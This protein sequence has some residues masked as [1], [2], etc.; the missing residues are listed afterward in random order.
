M[1]K[2]CA[3]VQEV[4]HRIFMVAQMVLLVAGGVS[5]QQPPEV[6]VENYVSPTGD[7]SIIAGPAELPLPSP[8]EPSELEKYQEASG[9]KN[10]QIYYEYDE[11]KLV[12]GSVSK[13]YLGYY[14]RDLRQALMP[15]G[16]ANVWYQKQPLSVRGDLLDRRFSLKVTVKSEG[17]TE[18]GALEVVAHAAYPGGALEPEAE[19]LEVATATDG[20]TSETVNLR[21][22]SGCL[23]RLNDNIGVKKDDSL[24]G[25]LGVKLSVLASQLVPTGTHKARAALQ[26][27]LLPKASAAFWRSVNPYTKGTPH[28]QISLSIPFSVENGGSAELTQTINIMFRPGIFRCG[29]CVLFGAV[30]A[31]ALSLLIS[32]QTAAKTMVVGGSTTVVGRIWAVVLRIFLSAVVAVIIFLVYTL[33]KGDKAVV[34]FDYAF[35]PTQLLPSFIIGLLVGLRPLFWWDKLRNVFGAGGGAPAQTG[36]AARVLLLG[37]LGLG[38]LS[39]SIE[40]AAGQPGLRP[41]NVSYDERSDAVYCLDSSSNV[42]FRVR[43]GATPRQ[44]EAMGKIQVDGL[45]LDH[46]L[47]KDQTRTW[48]AIVVMKGWPS[49]PG[50]QTF[51]RYSLQLAPLGDVLRSRTSL[52]AQQLTSVVG[53]P[54][55]AF[56]VATS[57]VF[58]DDQGAGAIFA[59]PLV[60][61]ELGPEELVF[62]HS[63][64]RSP[65]C[66]GVSGDKLFVGDGFTMRVYEI[67]LAQK[68][69]RTLVREV[70]DP[71]AVAVAPSGQTL[72]VADTARSRV[73]LC[74]LPSGKV[75]QNIGYKELRE[76]NGVA[77][78]S[79][80]H[81]WVSDSWLGALLEFAPDGHL[82]ARYRP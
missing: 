30:L 49:A 48:L 64:L 63:N 79:Q 71:T 65:Q 31:A 81:I 32:S 51:A 12:A 26:L 45:A 69:L 75:L 36:G 14:V 74:A 33:V 44:L 61:G 42:L 82:L 57:R 8:I 2:P 5:A 68:T 67:N 6:V 11:N 50:R 77:F 47:V 40:A 25:D 60:S 13:C 73:L 19:P 62:R 7:V 78:D 41:V 15:D 80:G 28:T 22:M 27:E 1:W 70:R 43:V 53:R 34:L 16:K 54:W 58:L 10:F 55:L 4:F 3:V 37:S 20:P 46:C 52:A 29:I 21:N 24:W 66:I 18:E 56:D 76:P 23:V 72:A 38:L 59:L 17:Q 39:L 35:D 9:L